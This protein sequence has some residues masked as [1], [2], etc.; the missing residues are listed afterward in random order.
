LVNCNSFGGLAAREQNLDAK[1]DVFSLVF[2]MREI[3]LLVD[4]EIFKYLGKFNEEH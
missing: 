4:V 1:S 2:N 3:L